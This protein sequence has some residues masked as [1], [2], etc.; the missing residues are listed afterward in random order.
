MISRL[1]GAASHPL[2]SLGVGFP[3]RAA[4][5]AGTGGRSP[6]DTPRRS[7]S[8]TVAVR[9]GAFAHGSGGI[10]AGTAYSGEAKGCQQ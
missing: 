10:G 5:A 6:R 8:L 3:S 2:P 7:S 4:L 1:G 9:A